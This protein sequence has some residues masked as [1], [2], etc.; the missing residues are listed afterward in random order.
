MIVVIAVVRVQVAALV[1]AGM[2]LD[3]AMHAVAVCL[4]LSVE[5]VRQVLEPAEEL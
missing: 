1:E 3:D 5:A 2:K 4:G